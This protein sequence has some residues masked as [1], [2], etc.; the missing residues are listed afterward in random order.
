[1]RPGMSEHKKDGGLLDVVIGCDCDPDRPQYGGTR[2]DTRAPLRWRGVREGIRRAREIAD[3]VRDDFGNP[4]RITWCVRSDLQMQEIYGDCAWAYSEF[5]DLWEHLAR[6]G[7]EIAW[8]PHLWRWHEQE[9]CWYQE[10]EDED[11]IRRCLREGHRALSDRMGHAP[12]TS[13]MGWEFHNNVTMQQ[14]N[15]LGIRVDFSAIPGRYTAGRPDKWGS[16]FNCHV[17]WRG[18]PEYPYHPSV[19]DFRTRADGHGTALDVLE[20]PMSVFRS[21]LLAAG[22]FARRLANASG[23]KGLTQVLRSAK[24]VQDPVKAYVTTR[25][26]IFAR[27]VMA[28]IGEAKR[29]GHATLVTAFHADDMCIERDRFGLIYD[30]LHLGTNLEGMRTRTKQAGV[31]LSFTTAS[32]ASHL[33]ASWTQRVE[34]PVS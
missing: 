27:L 4:A 9:A 1:M 24:S 19:L 7:D 10:I 25:P 33:P 11:W 6:C 14:L 2:Y 15:D 26:A 22:A 18:T 16:M 31:A 17:D 32:V 12:T 34:T 30:A 29:L 13:R 21:P 5:S 3:G 20:L 28:K 8:H 23:F